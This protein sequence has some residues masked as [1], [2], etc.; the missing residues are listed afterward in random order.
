[1]NVRKLVIAAALAAGFSMPAMAQTDT[2]GSTAVT[3]WPAFLQEANEVFRADYSYVAPNDVDG[4]GLSDLLWVNAEKNEV[5][6]WLSGWGDTY[7]QP[8]I[9]G[10]RKAF[11]VPAG[12]YVGA[13]GDLNGD[14]M[15]DLV[16]TNADRKLFLWAS[17][18][19]GFDST[20]IGTYPEGWQ[21]LGAGDIDGDNNAD[22]L[23]WNDSKCEF[24][25]W[26]MQG[27]TVLER[28]VIKATCGYHVAGFGH[29][30]LSNHLDLLWTSDAHD[31]YLWAG[32]DS[33]FMSTFL[34]NYDPQGHIIGTALAGDGGGI[35]V[36]VQNDAAMQFTQYEWVR[37]YDQQGNVGLTTF[38]A[39]RS[40][41]INQGDYLGATGNMDGANEAV[42]LWGNDTAN[43]ATTPKAPGRLTWY[44]STYGAFTPGSNIWQATAIA[45]YPTGWALLGSGH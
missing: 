31:V 29:F 16:L 6:Y 25:Y 24:G 27:A 18:G 1:M 13:T 40:L 34:G 11:H 42:L 26:R 28:K 14:R 39:I 2:G 12:Y 45:S 5:G 30:L 43:A 21:L 35:N 32:T 10:A 23:W 17:N 19:T 33:G 3:P 9:A 15:V 41:P 37:Y 20:H 4:D 22:L 38:N 44:T 7:P 36:Y 8:Y